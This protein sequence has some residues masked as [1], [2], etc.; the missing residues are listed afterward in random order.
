MRAVAFRHWDCAAGS[1]DASAG[2]DLPPP[3][4][5]QIDA[6]FARRCDLREQLAKFTRLAV[7]PPTLHAEAHYNL[8]GPFWPCYFERQDAGFT[9]CP[10]E[11]RYPILA[12]V[13][14]VEFILADSGITVVRPTKRFFVPVMRGVLPEVLRGRPK[15]PLAGDPIMAHLRAGNVRLP[16][17]FEPVPKMAAYVK[18]PL[19]QSLYEEFASQKSS[20]KLSLCRPIA[21]NNWLSQQSSFQERDTL[22]STDEQAPETPASCFTVAHG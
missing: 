1:S 16:E 10:L 14:L 21:L 18:P 15:T 9:R 20:W 17:T 19:M 7:L 6:T 3:F 11:V 8:S 22:E 2:S 4:P 12:D 5:E 13:R